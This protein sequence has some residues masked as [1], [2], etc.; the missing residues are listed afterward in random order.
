MY[1]RL[2]HHSGEPIYRQIVEA[3][4]YKVACGELAPEA[5]LPSIRALAEQLQI[6][7]R[8]VV[9]AYEELEHAG[10]VVM[11]QGQGVYV[12]VNHGVVPA[13]VRRQTLAELARRFLAEGARLGANPREMMQIV[14][15]E[16]RRISPPSPPLAPR[17][18]ARGKS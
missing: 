6:N 13:G 10:V 14:R 3:V 2:N 9:K 16:A 18:P 12:G 17:A 7:P 5:V 4:K 8:T 1:L 15:E 11:R